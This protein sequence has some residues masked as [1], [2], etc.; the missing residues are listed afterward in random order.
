MIDSIIQS[1]RLYID[2]AYEEVASKFCNLAGS[3]TTKTAERF[4]LSNWY[5][6]Y[7]YT[8]LLAMKKE[9]ER[10]PFQNRGDKTPYWSPSYIKQYK[11]LIIKLFEIN[12]VLNELGLQKYEQ[13]INNESN[14][15]EEFVKHKLGIIKNML[16]SY[17]NAGLNYLKEKYDNDPDLFDHHQS[18]KEIMLK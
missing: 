5:E 14:T 12:G 9:L 8:A 1:Q 7:I 6:G 4:L 17:S 16:D 11:F 10:V 13:I 15:G 2:N 18:L 3:N